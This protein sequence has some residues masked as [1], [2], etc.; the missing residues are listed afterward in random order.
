MPK[1]QPLQA[2]VLTIYVK[3]GII[4]YEFA[5]ANEVI[6]CNYYIHLKGGKAV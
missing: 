2:V 4:I 3:Y 1:C 6:L 5:N